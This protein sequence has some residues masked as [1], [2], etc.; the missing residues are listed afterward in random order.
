MNPDLYK[1]L[2][3]W[4]RKDKIQQ[5][6]TITGSSAIDFNAPA[7]RDD[8]FFANFDPFENRKQQISSKNLPDCNERKLQFERSGFSDGRDMSC[9]P[10]REVKDI[11]PLLG[12]KDI[13]SL[14]G[15]DLPS[16][17]ENDFSS[18]GEADL[19]S[20]METDLQ[21]MKEKDLPHLGRRDIPSLLDGDLPLIN[22]RNLQ[23][24]GAKDSIYKGRFQMI[25][26][27]FKNGMLNSL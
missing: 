22:H 12:E 27:D 5:T 14:A 2:K 7:P 17:E 24:F 10:M 23:S 3:D 15:G 13:K 1:L 18:M 9:L 4:N 21:P 20:L 25:D 6:A 26:V 8:N 19:P 11:P 16:R